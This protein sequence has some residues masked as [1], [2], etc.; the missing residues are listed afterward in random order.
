MAL[1]I[2][3]VAGEASGDLL[4]ADLIRAIKRIHPDASFDGIGG[5]RMLAEGFNSLYPMDR[6]SVMGFVEPL[7]RLPELLR[8]RRHLFRHFRDTKP[9]IVLGIDSP[10][11]VIPLERK[12]RDRG[13]CTAHYV[14]PS[15][16]AW[17]KGRVKKIARSVDLMLTLFPHEADFYTEHNVPVY[18]V[19]HPLAREIPLQDQGAAAREK[20]HIDADAKVLCLMP[21][22]RG[23]EVAQLLPDFLATAATLQRELPGLC[24]VLP[25]ANAERRGQIE[26]ALTEHESLKIKLLDGDSHTAMAA[27]DAILMASGTTSLEAMLLK[28]PMVVCYRFPRLTFAILRR[29]IKLPYF[30]LP[31]LLAGE[32]L[33]PERLQ[34]DVCPEVLVPLLRDAICDTEKREGLQQRFSE[35]H[36]SMAGDASA[37]A[38]EQLLLLLKNKTKAGAA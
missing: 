5:P 11:F 20:L 30:S 1:R 8:M 10:D 32:A 13:L 9:D 38:A 23:S 7:K 25:A 22:S 19:G 31:N 3:I 36:Q 24:C 18:C 27:A 37:L 12:L 14:S 21:G 33:V 35:I 6:L 4:G 34:D 2:G 29:L 28:R 17:R 15:V 16:W 26:A